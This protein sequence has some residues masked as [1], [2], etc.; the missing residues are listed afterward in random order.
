[1]AAH[2]RP[3][4]RCQHW[5]CDRPSEEELYNAANARSG[6]FCKAHAKQALRDFV[7]R[8]EGQR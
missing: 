5:N 8:V 3:L 1:M 7:A 2:L 6:V 4:T